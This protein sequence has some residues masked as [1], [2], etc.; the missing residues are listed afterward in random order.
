VTRSGVATQRLAPVSDT[1]FAQPEIETA[2]IVLTM[3]KQEIQR[4]LDR[5]MLA[6][7]R[8]MPRATA[9]ETLSELRRLL[10]EEAAK[11]RKQ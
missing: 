10:A 4:V 2:A 9:A 6:H 7:Q 5:L 3:T 1:V 8:R 11:A